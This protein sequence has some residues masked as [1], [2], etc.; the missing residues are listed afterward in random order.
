MTLKKVQ[1]AKQKYSFTFIS[2][3]SKLNAKMG[4]TAVQIY[5]LVIQFG[6]KKFSN[7]FLMTSQAQVL[8]DLHI[9]RV[10]AVCVLPSNARC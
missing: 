1:E 9:V 2:Y 6:M 7:N 10:A 3:G 8:E 4:Q 5:T